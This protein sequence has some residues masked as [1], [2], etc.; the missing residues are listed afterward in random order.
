MEKDY[1]T[2]V[3]KINVMFDRHDFYSPK[4]QNLKENPLILRDLAL[5]NCVEINPTRDY[6]N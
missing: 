2:F 3:T 1:V 6:N 5:N 4:T